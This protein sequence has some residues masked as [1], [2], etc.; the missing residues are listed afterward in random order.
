M[1]IIIC[2]LRNYLKLNEYFPS[3]KNAEEAQRLS[4]DG[5]APCNVRRTVAK[6]SSRPQIVVPV[7]YQEH[8]KKITTKEYM[9]PVMSQPSGSA[10]MRGKIFMK[11]FHQQ[12]G[13][14][15]SIIKNSLNFYILKQDVHL[16]N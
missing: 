7:Y 6:N 13:G 15:F 5:Y 10:L 1:R 12:V 8:P 14:L 2:S 4:E 11:S 3:Q 16:P 9:L